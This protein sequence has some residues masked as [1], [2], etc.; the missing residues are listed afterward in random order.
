MSGRGNSRP[1]PGQRPSRRWSATVAYPDR[2][3]RFRRALLGRPRS[4]RRGHRS[5]HRTRDA[6]AVGSSGPAPSIRSPRTPI[7]PIPPWYRRP[8]ALAALGAIAPAVAAVLIAAFLL[9]SAMDR[10]H[11][12]DTDTSPRQRPTHHRHP[13]RRRRPARRPRRRRHHRHRRR[14]AAEPGTGE[15][16]QHLRARHPRRRRTT[17]ATSP[18]RRPGR[19]TSACARRTARRS[20]ASPASSRTM[21]GPRGA[22][23]LSDARGA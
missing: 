10:R 12:L 7:G 1:V 19:R 11:R 16:R 3:R 6:R 18:R 9:L 22:A 4:R 21:T 8:S 2:F 17:G 5:A 14:A 20:P 13:P 15:P 23:L